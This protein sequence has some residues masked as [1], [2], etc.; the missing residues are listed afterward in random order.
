MMQKVQKKQEKNVL[1]P[2]A[3]STERREWS[4]NMKEKTNFQFR[5]SRLNVTHEYLSN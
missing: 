2:N 5:L 4:E 1:Q 3:L